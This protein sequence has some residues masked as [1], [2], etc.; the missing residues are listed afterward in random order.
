MLAGRCRRVSLS[1]YRRSYRSRDA[2]QVAHV[3]AVPDRP[4]RVV[5][6]EALE[7]GRGQEGCLSTACY[8]CHRRRSFSHAV[9]VR[10]DRE[11]GPAPADSLAARDAVCPAD[12]CR[13]IAWNDDCR[14]CRLPL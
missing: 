5:A 10:A 13:S 7:G 3:F 8:G 9:M 6:S 1:I 2:D 12:A 14:E 11:T 4:L